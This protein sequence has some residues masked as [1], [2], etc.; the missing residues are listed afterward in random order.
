[1]GMV[2]S[3]A[4][5]VDLTNQFKNDDF[6]VN[7]V[8]GAD[9]N[10]T[11]N[12]AADDIVLKGYENLGDGASDANYILFFKDSSSEKTETEEFVIDLEKSG[13]KIEE[14]DKYVIL[15]NNGD[16]SPDVDMNLDEIFKTAE[17]IFSSEGINVSADGNSIS[18]SG[19]GIEISDSEGE[20]VSITSEGI[21]IS[22][23]EVSGNGTFNVS[24][25]GDYD[26]KNSKY[27]LFLKNQ[28]KDSVIVISGDNMDVLKA[29]AETVTFN[30]N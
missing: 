28:N 17:D 2:I 9:F 18:L 3:A 30:E 6:G 23:D 15:E 21:S 1:M 29:M 11:L 7:V 4:S 25:D 12:I 22:G 8:S 16:Y 5:A 10:E 13:N 14:T 20:N 27:S 24:G 26:F 19:N